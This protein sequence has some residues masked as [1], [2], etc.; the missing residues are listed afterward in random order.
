MQIEPKWQFSKKIVMLHVNL[1][2]VAWKRARN[3][4]YFMLSTFHKS[5]IQSGSELGYAS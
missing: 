3:L 4:A 2:E 5:L 1:G